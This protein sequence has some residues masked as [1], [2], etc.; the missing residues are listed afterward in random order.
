MLVLHRLD[1][2]FLLLG[3]ESRNGHAEGEQTDSQ[4]GRR[5]GDLL[6]RSVIKISIAG[7]KLRAKRIGGCEDE[8]VCH[9]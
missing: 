4:P 9:R 1:E 3:A 8:G 2:R 7:H 6:L 5:H